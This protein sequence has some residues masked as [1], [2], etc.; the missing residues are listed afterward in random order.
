MVVLHRVAEPLQSVA[1]PL[2]SVA[3]PLRSVAVPLQ[4]GGA[5]PRPG[6]GGAPLQPMT[7]SSLRHR[8]GIEAKNAAI[9][10]RLI[11]DALEA[12]LVVLENEAA[13]KSERRYLPWWTRSAKASKGGER[14]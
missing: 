13:A 10:S 7:N 3:V 4:S 9:A 14:R 1:E 2:Q 8:F 5:P 12:G 6:G 11:R